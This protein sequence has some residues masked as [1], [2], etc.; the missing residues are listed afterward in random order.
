MSKSINRRTFLKVAAG[1]SALA[2][3]FS[4]LG[5]PKVTLGQSANKLDDLV[6]NFFANG[7]SEELI[8]KDQATRLSLTDDEYES[9]VKLSGEHV[10]KL[11]GSFESDVNAKVD[12]AIAAIK[13]LNVISKKASGVSIHKL[14]REDFAKLIDKNDQLLRKHRG[15][16][17]SSGKG[18]GLSR[19]LSAPC[20]FYHYQAYLGWGITYPNYTNYYAAA[21]SPACGDTDLEITYSGYKNTLGHSAE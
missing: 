9:F 15:R 11:A 18:V 1:S 19:P 14:S 6:T 3:S 10:K 12:N 21:G 5:F 4:V 2:S 8:Q 20:Y 7:R 16:V 17:A 13:E